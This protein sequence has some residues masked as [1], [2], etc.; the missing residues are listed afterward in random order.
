MS[1][2]LDSDVGFVE[3]LVCQDKAVCLPA[4]FVVRTPYR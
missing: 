4:V 2:I 3:G 1:H